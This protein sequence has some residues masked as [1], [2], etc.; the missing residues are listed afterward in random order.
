MGDYF[1]EAP[2]ANVLTSSQAE[3][4]GELRKMLD[5]LNPPQVVVEQTRATIVRKKELEIHIPHR[6]RP[7]E[8]LMITVDDGDIAVSFG[9]DHLHFDRKQHPEWLEEALHF[10]WGILRGNIEVE[11]TSRGRVP[12]KTRVFR[13]EEAGS[14]HLIE[15]LGLLVPFNPFARKRVERH[16]LSFTS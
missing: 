6:E 14:R 7:D 10:V 9:Y 3:V 16:V 4:L 15:T 2:P 11:I 5:A 8:S 13:V 12:L 1:A